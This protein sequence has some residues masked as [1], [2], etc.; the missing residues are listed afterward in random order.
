[1]KR[2]EIITAFLDLIDRS[3]DEYQVSSQGVE[4]EN[5]RQQDLLHDIEFTTNS[6]E[7]NKLCTKLHKCRISRRAHK[8]IEEES[9]II[10]EFFAD[11]QNKRTIDTMKQMLGKLR[12]IEGYHENRSYIRRIED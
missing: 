3:R 7:R 2:S 5:K 10:T 9:K 12:K 1:M 8:D 11:P 6:R 4:Y